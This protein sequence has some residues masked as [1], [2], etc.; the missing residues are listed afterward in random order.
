MGISG[1]RE[2]TVQISGKFNVNELVDELI[3]LCDGRPEEFDGRLMSV[4]KS[5]DQRESDTATLQFTRKAGIKSRP[6][7]RQSPMA[8]QVDDHGPMDFDKDPF[9]ENPGGLPR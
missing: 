8:E 5:T 1:K 9:D 2:V 3:D 6:R 4:Y 7:P